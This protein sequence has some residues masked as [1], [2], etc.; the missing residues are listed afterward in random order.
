MIEGQSRRTVSNDAMI[1]KKYD[2]R[3]TRCAGFDNA[4]NPS[5]PFRLRSAVWYLTD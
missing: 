1:A 2:Q 3:N 4:W 5:C